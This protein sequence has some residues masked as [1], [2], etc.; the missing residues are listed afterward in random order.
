MSK[1]TI[2]DVARLAGVSKKTVSRVINGSPLLS[3]KTREKVEAVIAQTGF[4][5]N[6]QARALALR[7]N[8]LVALVFDEA[9]APLVPIVS[10]ALEADLRET[11]HAL[12]L[13][14]VGA[15]A[16]GELLGLL[17]RHRPAG[18][19]LLAHKADNLALAALCAEFGATC[20]PILPEGDRGAMAALVH[21][22]VANGHRRI[23]FVAG[24]EGSPTAREREQ[25]YI[26]AIAVH[27]LDRG[28]SLFA[29]S[30]GTFASG[31]AAGRL[32]LS[33][34]PRPT[35]IV[36][37]ND[38]LAA[39]V[40]HAAGELG[41]EVPA[42]LSVTGFDDTP[43]ASRLWPPLTSVHVPWSEWS[44]AALRPLLGRCERD[45]GLHEPEMAV[46]GSVARLG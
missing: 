22:L 41:V 14:P 15:D 5:P 7:R 44:R 36:S 34:S 13:H 20:M 23:G 1:P 45:Y 9:G 42:M 39:G 28:A 19:L 43:L 11:G 3:V 10:V 40:I 30:E 31:I 21:W 38:E 29:A 27:G 24:P 37:V 35:V 18:V 25:G 4:V 12:I 2:N 6:P 8:F 26:D 33:V 17:E 32:L 16:T 46:R